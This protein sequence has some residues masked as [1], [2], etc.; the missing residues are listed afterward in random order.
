MESATP[1]VNPNHIR[2]LLESQSFLA[3]SFGITPT[4]RGTEERGKEDGNCAISTLSLDP[5]PTIFPNTHVI[6]LLTH[7]RL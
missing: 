7:G 5:F 1:R 2:P 3:M 6:L 4:P